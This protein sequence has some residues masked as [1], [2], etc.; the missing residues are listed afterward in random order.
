MIKYFPAPDVEKKMRDIIPK[1][2]MNYIDPSQV[3]CIRS[4]GSG[5]RRTIARCH[6]M[7]KVLQ[8]GMRRGAHY[9]IEVISKEFD[10][11]NEEEQTKVIIHELMH[12]PKN[13]GGG[14]RHHDYVTNRNVENMYRLYIGESNFSAVDKIKARSPSMNWFLF[15]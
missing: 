7:S 2:G 9:V 10:K 15:R 11:L 3:S 14:F 6:G 4:K 5:S 1:V 12:I 13:F 8:I